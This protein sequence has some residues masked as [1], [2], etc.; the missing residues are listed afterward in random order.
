MARDGRSYSKQLKDPR[1][2]KLRLR[3]LERDGWMCQLCGAEHL[4]LHV[5]H[6]FYDGRKPWEYPPD[7]LWTLCETCHEAVSGALRELKIEIGLAEPAF[8]FY[9][10]GVAAAYK[11]LND[12]YSCKEPDPVDCDPGFFAGFRAAARDLRL[13]G[14]DQEAY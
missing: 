8:V 14:F 12:P 3:I 9:L 2:Q 11:Y 6:G 10:R 4:T 7:S 5:H 1:W 13:P